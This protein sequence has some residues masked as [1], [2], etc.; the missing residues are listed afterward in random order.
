MRHVVRVTEVEVTL[1]IDAL[2]HLY[3]SLLVRMEEPYDVVWYI[4]HRGILYLVNRMMTHDSNSATFRHQDYIISLQE[5][6]ETWCRA[7]S[8]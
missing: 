2:E 8:S 3:V 7:V 1:E 5:P 4:Y 6:H